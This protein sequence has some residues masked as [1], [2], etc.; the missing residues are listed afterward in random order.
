MRLLQR[1]AQGSEC[2]ESLTWRFFLHVFVLRRSVMSDSFATP[3]TVVHQAPLSVEFSRQEYWNGLPFPPPGDL[4][5]PE[6]KL[7]FPRSPALTGRFLTTVPPGTPS[8]YILN[9]NMKIDRCDNIGSAGEVPVCPT[10]SAAVKAN[11]H[12]HSPSDIKHPRAVR[13]DIDHYK[14]KSQHS[15][16]EIIP[17]CAICLLLFIHASPAFS[18]RG[19][20]LGPEATLLKPTTASRALTFLQGDRHTM[21]AV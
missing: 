4:P 9:V 2:F 13:T 5:D 1:W 6:I 11:A 17:V 8:L 12:P 7:T 18:F 20:V 19:P 3:W 10:Q 15:L 16:Q 14:A 21:N